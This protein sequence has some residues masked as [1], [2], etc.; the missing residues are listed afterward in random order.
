MKLWN[1]I[2]WQT[3]VWWFVKVM[4]AL[5]YVTYTMMT[6]ETINDNNN[7]LFPL[8]KIKLQVWTKVGIF[9]LSHHWHDH[10]RLHP[11]TTINRVTIYHYI[12]TEEWKLGF[13]EFF[14][15]VWCSKLVLD[16]RSKKYAS[17]DSHQ[18]TTKSYIL[19]LTKYRKKLYNTK[20]L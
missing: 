18:I 17:L 11:A 4:W 19:I 10:R 2:S 12:L 9:K 8:S 3:L 13:F 7:L 14:G 20:I 1:V 6:M 15:L 5:S 16:W